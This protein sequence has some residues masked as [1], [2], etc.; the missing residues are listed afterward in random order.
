MG[1]PG[2]RFPII[3]FTF[4]QDAEGVSR[5]LKELQPLGA[6][7]RPF[8]AC[9][10]S[11]T[12]SEVATL[13]DYLQELAADAAVAAGDTLGFNAFSASAAYREQARKTVQ[14]KSRTFILKTYCLRYEAGLAQSDDFSWN[15]TLAFTDGVAALPD[16]FDGSSSE[17]QGCNPTLWRENSHDS[18]CADTNVKTWMNF[19]DQFGTHY[20]VK[21][22]A[23]GKLTQQITMS[24]SDIAQLTSSGTNVK[25]ALKATFGVVSGG[26]SSNVS[27]EAEQ[28][29]QLKHFQYETETLIVGGRVPKDVSDPDSMAE[30]SDTVEE[31]PMPVKIT[32]QSLSYLL[33]EEKKEA[34]EKASRF[35]AEAVGMSRA[36]LNAM[37]GKVESIG[38]VLRKA[39]QVTYA[40]DPPG[41]AFCAPH[42]RVLLGF[43]LQLNFLDDAAI[44]QDAEIK[45]CPSGRDKCDGIEKPPKEGD[46]ARIFALCGPEPVAGLEQV[47]AQGPAKAMAVC[48]QGSVILSGFTLSLAGGREGLLKTTFFPCRAGVPTCSVLATRGIEKNFVWIACVDE[49]TPGLQDIVNVAETVTGVASKVTNMDGT[50]KPAGDKGDALRGRREGPADRAGDRNDTLPDALGDRVGDRVRDRVGDRNDR[51]ADQRLC[52]LKVCDFGSAA[53]FAEN[54]PTAYLVSRFYRAPEIIIGA[55]Y[56]PQIDVWAAAATLYELATGQVLFQGRTNN[57]ML[58]CIMEY[59]GKLPNKLIRA[60]QLAHLHFNQDLE[61]VFKDKDPFSKREVPKVLRD[62]RPCRS[63]TEALLERQP[64]WLKGNSPKANFVRKKLKQFGDLIE[65]CLILDPQKRLTPDEALQHPFVKETIHFVDAGPR[66]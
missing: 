14:K 46:D 7:S 54:T 1:D 17:G 52:V 35:Y 33:P 36:D 58:R 11:E 4:L 61:F 39:T 10:Q 49:K 44:A 64:C 55:K 62:L 59:R 57:D 43:A 27:K 66:A 60:G 13:A 9:K 21:L 20:I 25:S 24:N 48:P 15:Y 28:R 56:G 34:F 47:V 22:F 41:Y 65:K 31:L 3:Q 53:D 40:G 50:V 12:L 18:V 42:E 26:V 37:G 51:A 23:G 45:A 29:E 19:I 8:V 63:V 2:L 38:E 32:I 16:V 6:Y 5:D 30:W